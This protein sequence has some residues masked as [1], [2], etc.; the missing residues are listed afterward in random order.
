[1]IRVTIWNE[2]DQDRGETPEDNVPRNPAIRAVHPHGINETLRG[3]F[4]PCTDMEITLATQDMEGEGLSDEL[5]DRT[6]VLVY[7]A[8]CL[9]EQLSDAAAERV[10]QHVLH[11]MGFMPLHSC[12]LYTSRCV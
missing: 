5:L 6:D 4:A 1:M 8:H 9:H 3:V 11:G 2:H 10:R 7:W 12:L